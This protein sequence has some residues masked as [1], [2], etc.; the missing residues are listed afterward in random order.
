MP[1]ARSLAATALL[2]LL[3]PAAAPGQEED[4]PDDATRTADRLDMSPWGFSCVPPEGWR[5]LPAWATHE[6]ARWV[7]V[8]ADGRRALAAV[9]VMVRPVAEGVDAAE[10]LANHRGEVERGGGLELT[11]LDDLE[12]A[13]VPAKAY[14]VTPTRGEGPPVAPRGLLCVREGLLYAVRI[15]QAGAEG[16]GVAAWRAL[17]E[18]W[19]WEEVADPADHLELREDPLGIGELL[20]VRV[21]ELAR[22]LPT[23]DGPPRLVVHDLRARRPALVATVRPAQGSGEEVRAQVAASLTEQLGL[24]E[25]PAWTPV[26]AAELETQ[27]LGPVA[28]PGRGHVLYAVVVLPVGPVPAIGIEFQVADEGDPARWAEACRAI[29]ASARV[30]A[31]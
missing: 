9:Q 10:A 29:A 31:R 17:R 11:P 12:L 22:Q 24:A 6:A 18:S 21:P 4:A 30:P 8:S 15:P 13:G 16:Q 27:L 23:R 2:A 7:D 5:R 26:E 25:D 3:L 1:A 14:Q 20:E 28:V 19:R